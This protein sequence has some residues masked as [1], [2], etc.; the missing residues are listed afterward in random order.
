MVNYTD[1]FLCQAVHMLSG[2]ALPDGIDDNV[3]YESLRNKTYIYLTI[4][5]GGHDGGVYMEQCDG[6]HDSSVVACSQD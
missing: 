1:I 6:G 2:F 3:S 5:L 4:F